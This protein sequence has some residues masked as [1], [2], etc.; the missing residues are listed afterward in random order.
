MW[1]LMDG[2]DCSF[3]E[4]HFHHHQV[5]VVC[6]YLTDYTITGIFPFDVGGNLEGVALCIHH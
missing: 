1:V 4:L 2:A 3:F 5:F 6:H